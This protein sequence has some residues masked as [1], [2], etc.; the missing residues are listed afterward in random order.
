VV[1]SVASDYVLLISPLT[2]LTSPR[3]DELRNVG[4][5]DPTPYLEFY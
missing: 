4:L 2:Q 3:A 5:Q 1:S